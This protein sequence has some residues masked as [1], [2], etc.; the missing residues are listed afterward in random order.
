MSGIVYLWGNPARYPWV[1]HQSALA[2]STGDP[3]VVGDLS[4]FFCGGPPRLSM[5]SF[6]L[7]HVCAAAVARGNQ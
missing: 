7:L 4:R 1:P 3:W 5:A 6:R 2:A